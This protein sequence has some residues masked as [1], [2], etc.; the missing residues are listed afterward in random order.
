M[1]VRYG[2][3]SPWK[4]NFMVGR[5]AE[6]GL[7]GAEDEG[8]VGVAHAGGELPKAPAV[9]VWLSVPSRISPGRQWPSSGR[10]L[11]HTPL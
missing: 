9:Q 11:W 1:A 4:A 7:A 10:A 5:H 8:G 3:I 6:P 2:G